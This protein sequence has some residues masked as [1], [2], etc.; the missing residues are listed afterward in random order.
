MFPNLLHGQ[1]ILAG[2]AFLLIGS[3][4]VI[5]LEMM[6]SWYSLLAVEIEKN[7]SPNIVRALEYKKIESSILGIV[8]RDGGF[9][10]SSRYCVLIRQLQMR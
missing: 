4:V 10:K 1:M 3:K 7:V 2:I 5:F 6:L 9:T 8:G